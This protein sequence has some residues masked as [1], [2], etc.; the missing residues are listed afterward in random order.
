MKF[1]VAAEI[2]EHAGKGVARQLR[3]QGKIPAVLYGQGEC[4]L[5][6]LDPSVVTGIVRG[7]GGST[8]LIT[9]NISGPTSKSTR[10]ALLRDY[11]VD[12]VTGEIL[13]ADLFEVSMTKAI[14]IKVPVSLVGGTPAGVKEGGV[15]HHNLR[16][17]QIECLP[18]A[19]PDSIDVDA[20]G[21]QI[22]QGIHIRD[23]TPREGLRF[24]DEGDQMVVSVAAP[25]SEA[26][27]EALLTSGVGVE[28]A[29]EPEVI[30]KGKEEG[31]EAAE[32]A[33]AAEAKGEKKEAKAEKKETKEEKKK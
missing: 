20:S 18:S 7:H 6:T 27:L 11:Q 2:R 30:G 17:L 24:L 4:L 13:H 8:A 33:G 19:I 32:K 5:L 25:I 21:L 31:E 28:E 9:L 15:L 14:R 26:K 1:D 3:R 23:L 10:T 22:N 12:P 16:E 29:K